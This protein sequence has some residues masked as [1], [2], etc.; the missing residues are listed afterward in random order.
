MHKKGILVVLSGFS[1]SGK[2]TLIGRLL[3]DHA[4]DYALSVSAT[5]REPRP[6][7]EE[8]VS[9]FFVTRECFEEMIRQGEL[10]EHACYVGNYYGTP[11]SYVSEQMEAGRSVIL[12]IELQGALQIKDLFPQTRLIFV[13]PPSAAI[14]RDRLTDRGT[15]T[16]EVIADRL[17]RAVEESA[18]IADY[19]Y[20]IINDKLEE[21]VEDLHRVICAECEGNPALVRD[22]LVSENTDFIRRIRQDLSDTFIKE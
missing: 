7:E 3:Q 2:G 15:E 4:G 18:S 21:A 20:I 6:G 1:G 9:Y 10:L 22:R 5:T 13:T 16:P 17:R 8:G 11:K 12:E 14:L 19:D